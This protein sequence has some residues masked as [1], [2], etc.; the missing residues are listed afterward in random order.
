[1]FDS[2]LRIPDAA[3]VLGDGPATIVITTSQ[4]SPSRRRALI[5]RG[6]GVDVVP[7]T[8]GGVS[9]AD[10]LDVLA[11]RGITTI[12]VEGGA[13][14]ATSLLADGLV[15]RAIVAIAPTVLGAG[16]DAIGDLGVDRISQAIHLQRSLARIVGRDVVLAG[17][18]ESLD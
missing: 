6:I 1:V 12:L 17:D 7:E 2:R 16:T 4:S 15:H 11:L 9:L 3:R 14:V 10:A 18:V 8:P 13:R 5:E